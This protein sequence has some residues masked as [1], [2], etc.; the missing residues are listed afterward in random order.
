MT[1][2]L[3]APRPRP[4][5][6]HLL[7]WDGFE[8]PTIA[9]QLATPDIVIKPRELHLA[10]NWGILRSR[11]FSRFRKLR[12]SSPG[13]SGKKLPALSRSS[14]MASVRTITMTLETD[15][16]VLI[17]HPVRRETTYIVWGALMAVESAAANVPPRH[18]LVKIAVDEEGGEDL[19]EDARLHENLAER[20]LTG[21]Y[22]IFT[23]S[24]GSTA[25]VIDDF[26]GE[27]RDVESPI[28]SS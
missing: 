15:V 14:T 25:L 5:H 10:F 12:L 20:G 2:V 16:G 13:P 9:R 27:L 3:H 23:D 1:L 18:V 19:R 6:S 26:D 28:L 8:L 17:T 4:T 24:I 7:D 22:G 11:N 21:Y